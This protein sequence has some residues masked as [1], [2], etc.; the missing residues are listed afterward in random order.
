MI[1]L[2]EIR[3]GLPDGKLIVVKEGGTIPKEIPA[4]VVKALQEIGSIGEPQSVEVVAD[5]SVVT[6]NEELKKQVEELKKQLAD[7]EAEAAA[8]APAK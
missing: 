8:K 5:A 7:A 2:T 6:E 4:S 1:A 3:H